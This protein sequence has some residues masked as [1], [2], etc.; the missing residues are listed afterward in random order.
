MSKV[1]FNYKGEKTIIQCQK[2]EKLQEICQK[3]ANKIQ[4]DLNEFF[5]LYNGSQID[6]E[7]TFINLINEEDK[8]RDEMNI[9]AFEAND[10]NRD[11]NIHKI[12]EIICPNCKENTFIKFDQYTISLSS[13][14]NGHEIKNLSMIDYDS[15]Q[16]LDFSKI[17]C[18]DC[19][20]ANRNNSFNKIFFKCLDCGNALCPLC[21]NQHNNSHK[22]IDIDK[23]NYLCSAHKDTFIRYCN[24]C[25]KNLCLKCEKD[26]KD[27]NSIYFGDV[28]PDDNKIINSN[29]QIRETID[30][31]NKE[32]QIIIERLNNIIKNL[33]IYNNK[34]NDIIDIY[35]ENRNYQIIHN[36][37]EFINNSNNLKNDLENIICDNSIFNKLNKLMI[38]YY[39]FNSKS[40]QSNIENDVIN[41]IKKQ[42]KENTLNQNEINEKI[43]IK[44]YIFDYSKKDQEDDKDFH[45]PHIVIDNGSTL[46]RAGFSGD[47]GPTFIIPNCIGHPNLDNVKHFSNDYFF[48]Q[49]I[50]D[51]RELLNLDYPMQRG[52]VKDFNSFELIYEHIFKNEMRVDE[53]EHNIIISEIT[54]NSVKN[55]EQIGERIFEYFN[56]PG[57]FFLN[58]ARSC[59]FGYGEFDGLVVDLSDSFT[60]ICPFIGGYLMEDK[61][62]WYKIGGR[63][64]TDYMLKLLVRNSGQYIKYF[65]YAKLIKE[66][67]CYCA[68][69]YYEELKSVESVNYK[70]PDSEIIVKDE[71]IMCPEVLF[72]PKILYKEEDG[73]AKVCYDI[74]LDIYKSFDY[75]FFDKIYLAGGNSMINGF[76]KRF[77]NKIRELAPYKS[78]QS[79]DLYVVAHDDRNNKTFL[80]CSILS[81]LSSFDSKIIT[82]TEY[83]ESGENIFGRK[84]FE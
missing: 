41:K 60:H 58:Q 46:I 19:N 36:I 77:L 57:L 45:F 64:L 4:I 83:E 82:K 53:T 73:I 63:D 62:R 72:N 50:E 40:S 75:F 79:E 10:A 11:E 54:M 3:F 42:E 29:N 39:K 2:E 9:L 1:I 15:L 52:I 18:Q 68:L 55:R 16:T 22:I 59:L 69:D 17:I 27:H 67:A 43:E 23:K 12:K 28:L 56:C 7:L 51:N 14:K 65:E 44:N 81:S 32:I 21:K 49:Q 48:G 66:K 20:N 33:K 74:L 35:N 71:R 78:R 38:L 61:A 70:L 76:P 47:D 6:K 34:F 80:G 25:K 8:Q 37:N 84:G 5:F 13:C 26:H 24:D 31:F 30:Q